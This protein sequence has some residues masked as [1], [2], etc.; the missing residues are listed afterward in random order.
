MA[1]ADV[2]NNLTGARDALVAA[3]NGKGG[4]V[5]TSAT[6]RQC[7]E[8]VTAL[9]EGGGGGSSLLQGIAFYSSL[10][11]VGTSETADQMKMSGTVSVTSVDGVTSGNF[12]G[13]SYLTVETY[14]KLPKFSVCAWI[15]FN[16][17]CHGGIIA[18]QDLHFRIFLLSG[19][20]VE[21]TAYGYNASQGGEEGR[22]TADVNANSWHNVIYKFD[23]QTY[24]LYID[25]S[26]VST[27][28][29]TRADFV[30][31]FD[32]IRIGWH[33][34]AFN[35]NI[36]EAIIYNRAL[37]DKEIAELYALG[38]GG[39][40]SVWNGESSSGGDDVGSGE[41]GDGE[42]GGSSIYTG[43]LVATVYG[44]PVGDI[45]A[46]LTCVNPDAIRQN[47][48]VWEGK[49]TAIIDYSFSVN[50]YSGRWSLN[51]DTDMMGD[52]AYGGD[53]FT[54]DNSVPWDATW[55]NTGGTSRTC[56]VSKA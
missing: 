40:S 31:Y 15:N 51:V 30:P 39:F 8:A 24:F 48:V 45:T 19:Q 27:V 7:A 41:S 23:G 44:T 21:T 32:N 25:G 35:G 12:N 56:E 22:M 34:S 38:P 28:E 3:I 42:G 37:T 2:L 36:S 43:D 5:A 16:D 11:D 1:L 6:L 54:T 10:T 47:D 50:T 14:K 20:H 9:P 33:N 55:T 53:N 29:K 17:G 52:I 18:S 13:S 46:T 49:A 4:T 26:T